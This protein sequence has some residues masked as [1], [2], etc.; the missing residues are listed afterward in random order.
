MDPQG[1]SR[2]EDCTGTERTLSRIAGLQDPGEIDESRA[3]PGSGITP[4]QDD[5]SAARGTALD[6]IEGC[7]YRERF[8][9][10]VPDAISVG[11]FLAR[12][13]HAGAVVAR[14]AD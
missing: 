13:G 9:A 3:S 10:R 12:I 7:D 8:L 1:D 4:I 6:R 5:V 2:G 14:V 11:I